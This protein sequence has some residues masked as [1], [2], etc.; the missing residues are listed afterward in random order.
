MRDCFEVG[1]GVNACVFD[2]LLEGA[3]VFLV[4]GEVVY[5]SIDADP[6][7]FSGVVFLEF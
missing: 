3:W 2:Q 5:E 6:E 7:V 4:G 1:S